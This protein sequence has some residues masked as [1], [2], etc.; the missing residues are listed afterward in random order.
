MSVNLILG[1][2]LERMM[3]IPDKSVDL[4]LC[5]L[6]YGTTACKW[7]S[8]IPL[9]MLWQAYYRVLKPAGAIVLTA[10]QP[11]TTALAASNLKDFKYDLVWHKS[12]SGSAFTAKYRP[13]AKHE[14]IL[15]FAKGKT[16]YNPQMTEGEPY[17]RTR[18]PS[19][20]NNHKLGLGK[21][22]STTVNTGFRYPE[23]VI[24][25]QQKW[26]RQDQVHP[27]Q[28]PVELMEYL[29]NTY[30][31][32]GETVLDNC[33]GSGTTGIACVNTG[34]SFIGIE[35]DEG[36]FKVASERIEKAREAL[37]LAA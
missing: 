33:M 6:P 30:S 28:K 1:D 19:E 27:T 15:V 20:I 12:K 14:S 9:E 32:L 16:T 18:Q 4:V 22:V 37:L 36:Y 5:D 3:E 2:C 31:N 34:R 17:T 29:I 26:R 13:M 11:F 10:C 21:E 25:F 35:M 24:F 7:D 8:V 23:S